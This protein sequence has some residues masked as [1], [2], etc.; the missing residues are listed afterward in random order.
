[1]DGLESRFEEIAVPRDPDCP[2]C[3]A[4]AVGGR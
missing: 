3:G 4:A 2:S 1:V